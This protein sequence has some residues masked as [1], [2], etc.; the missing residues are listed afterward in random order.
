MTLQ[1]KGYKL[2][3]TIFVVYFVEEGHIVEADSI[4]C[5][6]DGIFSAFKHSFY[7]GNPNGVAIFYGGFSRIFTEE[8]AEIRF[9]HTA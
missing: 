1:E 6:R 2:G 8:F 3:S 7:M 5:F 9:A 4:R